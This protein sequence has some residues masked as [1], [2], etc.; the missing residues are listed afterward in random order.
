[1]SHNTVILLLGTNLGDKKNNLEIAY[2]LINKEIGQIIK[3]SEI[4]E[5][6]AEGF[7]SANVF[8]NQTIKV[9]TQLSP[10]QLL[11]K[12]K[13]IEKQMGRVYL[14]NIET[15]QDRVID[16]DIL[17]FNAIT[18]DSKLLKIPHHQI[19]SRN[20]VKKIRNYLLIG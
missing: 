8:F 3:K 16:I 5:N 15:Y 12:I 2:S 20:F 18:Y 9:E 11:E 19:N 17:I 6:P 1:M 7:E 10:I 13:T 4:L 14:P